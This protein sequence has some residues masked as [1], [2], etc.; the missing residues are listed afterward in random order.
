MIGGA[1]TT[2]AHKPFGADERTPEQ[3]GMRKKRD[4]LLGGN[5]KSKF[6]MVLQ[7]FANAEPVSNDVNPKR[8]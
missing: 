2:L 7:V 5:L 8:A 6:E 3:S 4:R 1:G